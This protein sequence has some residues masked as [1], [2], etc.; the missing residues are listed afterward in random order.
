MSRYVDTQCRHGIAW[1]YL[2]IDIHFLKSAT[3]PLQKPTLIEPLA[4]DSLQHLYPQVAW[5]KV[6]SLCADAT[7]L[8]SAGYA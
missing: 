5:D 6:W 7:Q 8:E 3:L 4:C 2:R 1:I